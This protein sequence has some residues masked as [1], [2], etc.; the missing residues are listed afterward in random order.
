M[1]LT[2]FQISEHFKE[3][4]YIKGNKFNGLNIKETLFKVIIT[5]KALQVKSESSCQQANE[6][7]NQ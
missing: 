5:K 4:S 1:L 2:F 7:L 3:L 6:G